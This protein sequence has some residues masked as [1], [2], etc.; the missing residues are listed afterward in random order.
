MKAWDEALDIGH[1]HGFRNA[2]A[3]VLAPTGTISF[4]M[5]CD[6]TGIEPGFSLL[7]YKTLV[8]GGIMTLPLQTVPEGLCALGYTLEQVAAIE[9]HLLEHGTLQRAPGL[10]AEHLPVFATAVGD[11][12]ISGMGHVKMLAAVQPFLSGAVSKTVNLGADATVANITELYWAAWKSGVKALA[13]YRDGSKTQQVL[14]TSKTEEQ[15]V[16]AAPEGLFTQAELDAAVTDALEQAPRRRRRMPS[17]RASI[18]H[19]FNIGG[20]GGYITVGLH[21]DGTPGEVFLT[22]VGKEGSTLRGMMNSFA[23]ALSMLLQY[24]VPLETLVEKFAFTRFEPEG[25]T[26]NSEIPFAKSMPDYIVRWMA[27]RFLDASC[28][29]TLGI[30]TAG[31]KAA[32]QPTAVTPA[33]VMPTSQPSAPVHVNGHAN[34]NGNGRHVGKIVLRP[35]GEICGTCGS[36]DLQTTGTCK[37]CRS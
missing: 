18:T 8:G 37:A 35:N 14:S 28:H 19:K 25:I 11:D 29:E 22:G 27:S 32:K 21:E 1:R 4:L 3:T 24:G 34:G 26:R 33:A 17:E 36:A 7:S 9:Q 16:A 6:T 10:A 13:I 12:A 30:Q 15:P 2:Q 23:T 31:V 20:H 5:D